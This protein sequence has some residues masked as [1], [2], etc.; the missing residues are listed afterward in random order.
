MINHRFIVVD[1]VVVI[2][3]PTTYNYRYM[4]TIIIIIKH[5]DG[6]FYLPFFAVIR[7]AP[8]ALVQK[9]FHP[10]SSLFPQRRCGRYA[11]IV[12][13]ANDFSVF[14][15]W[16]ILWWQFIYIYS[17]LYNIKNPTTKNCIPKMKILKCL[18]E[19]EEKRF[20]ERWLSFV[21]KQQSFV[22]NELIIILFLHLLFFFATISISDIWC[23]QLFSYYWIEHFSLFRTADFKEENSTS[24]MLI[25]V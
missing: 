16:V 6:F 4:Y 18:K 14:C 5:I 22:A 10:D 24:A 12:A 20:N 7:R 13:I 9:L 2:I 1:V 11:I 19:K 8:R 23:G 25:T 3:W 21:V 17:Y 15:W